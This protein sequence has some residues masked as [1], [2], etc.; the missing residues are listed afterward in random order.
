MNEIKEDLDKFG[1]GPITSGIRK[2]SGIPLATSMA[3]QYPEEVRKFFL[4]GLIKK[5]DRDGRRVGK[6]EGGTREARKK[7]GGRV[8]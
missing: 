5:K 2:E 7:A 4:H 6:R 8:A 1:G 3:R